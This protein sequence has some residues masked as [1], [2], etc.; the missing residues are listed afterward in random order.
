MKNKQT[1]KLFSPDLNA[2]YM[3]VVVSLYPV[4]VPLIIV[5]VHIVPVQQ[6]C[7]GSD[8]VGGRVCRV[9]LGSFD[10]R[11]LNIQQEGLHSWKIFK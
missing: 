7:D 2:S 8:G 9:Q 6:A 4:D 10:G 5:E 3:C 11:H 1:N